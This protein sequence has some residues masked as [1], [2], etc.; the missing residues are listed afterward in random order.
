MKIIE[1]N[2]GNYGSTGNIMKNIAVAAENAGHEVFC[3]CAKSRTSL[4][5]N[6]GKKVEYIGTILGRKLHVWLSNICCVNG[7]LSVFDTLKFIKRIDQIN[8]DVIHL[9]N[10]HNAYINIPLLINYIKKKNLRVL[11][12][13]HDCWSFTGHCAYYDLIECSKWINGCEKCP[14]KYSYPS[15]KIDDS[16]INYRRKKI[17]FTSIDIKLIT[18]SKWL[19]GEVKKSFLKNQDVI[20]INNGIDLDRFKPIYSNILEKYNCKE[21]IILLGVALGW[22]KRKGLDAFIQLAE[23]LDSRFQIVLVGTTET[24]IEK[25]PASVITIPRTESIEELAQIY[26]SAS[27]FVNPTMEENFPTVN[28]E[29]LACGTPVL[30][31]ST[32]GAA[33]MLTAETGIVVQRGNVDALEKAIYKFASGEISFDRN[34]CRKQAEKYSLDEMT[35]KYISLFESYNHS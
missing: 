21:K 3:F 9:H 35:S 24:D 7:C 27:I 20:V 19:A 22:G 4:R 5:V 6:N 17:W 1:V 23:R 32:G 11:W 12:T 33:E 30:T 29:A 15:T 2:S 34:N 10:I 16:K 13:L 18:P 25:L 14:A 31:Y 8:P 28:L 26:T